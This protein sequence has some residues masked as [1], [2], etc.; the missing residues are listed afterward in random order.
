[1]P[2]GKRAFSTMDGTLYSIHG[3]WIP[4]IHAGMT[5]RFSQSDKVELRAHRIRK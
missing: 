5:M 4:A 2:A 1:M 3:N